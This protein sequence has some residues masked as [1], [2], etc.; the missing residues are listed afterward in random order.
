MTARTVSI[1][2]DPSSGT[3]F[4]SFNDD[5][6]NAV[7]SENVRLEPNIFLLKLPKIASGDDTNN[8]AFGFFPKTTTFLLGGRFSGTLTQRRLFL[9]EVYTDWANQANQTSRVYTSAQLAKT[10]NVVCDNFDWTTVKGI[11]SSLEWNMVL[12]QVD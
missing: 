4:D 9:Q 2:A 6:L 1:L 10:F 3:A 11:V 12:L 5:T 7:N 8:R